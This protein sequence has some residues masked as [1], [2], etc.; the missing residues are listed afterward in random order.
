MSCFTTIYLIIHTQEF[1]DLWKHLDLIC[2]E[3]PLADTNLSRSGS[4]VVDL[5]VQRKYKIIRGGRYVWG[6]TQQLAPGRCVS[7]FQNNPLKSRSILLT[8]DVLSCSRRQTP[9]FYPNK[10]TNFCR[11]LGGFLIF[12]PKIFF[13]KEKKVCSSD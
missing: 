8:L 4:T 2:D 1:Q 5:S 12:S 9:I 11:K 13:A 6:I 7:L 3:G 10:Y